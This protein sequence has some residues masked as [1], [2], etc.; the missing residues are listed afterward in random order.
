MSN[1]NKRYASEFN[2]LHEEI[3]AYK[4]GVDLD[5]YGYA[6]DEGATHDEAM[7]A[8]KSGVDLNN[9]GYARGSG[10]T[11]DEVMQAHKAGV[12][13][14]SYGYARRSGATHDETMQAH[15]SGVDLS[16]YGNARYNGATH[17]EVIQV[18]KLRDHL[19]NMWDR[20][21]PTQEELG[22]YL[23]SKN[24][25]THKMSNWAQRYANRPDQCRLCGASDDGTHT[26]VSNGVCRDSD[27]CEEAQKY[28]TENPQPEAP[29]K[30][31]KAPYVDRKGMAACSHGDCKGKKYEA[32]YMHWTDTSVPRP[33][34]SDHYAHAG[35]RSLSFSQWKEIY[36]R[37]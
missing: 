21:S 31:R 32:K 36:R 4:E 28:L 10:A 17:N 16:S 33:Y 19:E 6:K 18:H 34:C 14:G 29:K 9:Y 30:T 15:K 8:N 26:V 20:E 35:V 11:H 12:N 22:P 5:N 13:V 2:N 27:E 1:W 25:S 3:E 23:G 7:Q 24:E 37:K